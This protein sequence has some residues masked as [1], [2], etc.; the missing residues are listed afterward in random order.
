MECRPQ[1]R[2]TY[3]HH[4]TVPNRNFMN[5]FE[6]QSQTAFCGNKG[7]KRFSQLKF[8]EFFKVSAHTNRL[9]LIHAYA[10]VYVDMS[11]QQCRSL[12]A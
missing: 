4:P 10:L 5:R 7:T 2:R 12:I 3:Q 1:T 9:R 11:A 8:Y 6:F